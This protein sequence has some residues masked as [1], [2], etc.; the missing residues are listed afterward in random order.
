MMKKNTG[1]AGGEKEPVTFWIC[2][3]KNL[4]AKNCTQIIS[5]VRTKDSGLKHYICRTYYAYFQVLLHVGL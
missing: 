4:L 1:S 2:G 5:L 3:E